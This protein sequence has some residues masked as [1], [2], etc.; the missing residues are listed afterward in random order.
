[1]SV[2]N[3][4]LGFGTETDADIYHT[5]DELLW[6]NLPEIEG[7]KQ[8]L[9]QLNTDEEVGTAHRISDLEYWFRQG[10]SIV[11]VRF[12]APPSPELILLDRS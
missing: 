9:S 1:M 12:N 11:A 7:V 2:E 10:V 6:V 3:F 4:Y 5:L 8:F